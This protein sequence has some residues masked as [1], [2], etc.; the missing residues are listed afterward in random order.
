MIINPQSK[1][2]VC[3]VVYYGPPFSGKSTSLRQ[4]YS[5]AAST[6]KDQPLTLTEQE[7]RTL[8]FDFLPLSLGSVKGYKIRLHLYSVPGQPQ[9][10]AT[11]KIILKGVDGV[12]FVADSQVERLEGNQVSWRNL[13]TNL[14][15]NDCDFKT[16]PMVL[17][18]NKRDLKG[19][20]PIEAIV[21]GLDGREVPHMESVALQGK[22]VMETLN[23]VAKLVLK[24]LKKA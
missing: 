11:R 20:A 4:I 23:T 22:G 15:D 14:R 16:L 21:Q 24:G 5:A 17:Q 10:D 13:K 2:I 3:K 9:F 1:E 8:F 6:S 18:I 19:V 7:D 12:V